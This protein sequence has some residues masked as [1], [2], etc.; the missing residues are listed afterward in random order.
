[1]V[2]LE[3]FPACIGYFGKPVEPNNCRTCEAS[4]LCIRLKMRFIPKEQLKPIAE[5]IEHVEALLTGG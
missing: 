4:E 2:E 1:M 3:A 5:L